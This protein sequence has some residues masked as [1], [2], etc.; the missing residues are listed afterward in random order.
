LEEIRDA[1]LNVKK[2]ATP[3]QINNLKKLRNYKT[4][5][6]IRIGGNYRIGLVIRN[7][8][9]WFACFGHRNTFYKGFP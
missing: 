4:H 9:V 5:Y 2:A 3:A 8:T 1:I 6:R 7:K